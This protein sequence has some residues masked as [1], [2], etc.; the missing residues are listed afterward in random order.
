[1]PLPGM[2]HFEFI[3]IRK[4]AATSRKGGRKRDERGLGDLST[5]LNFMNVV[6]L[7]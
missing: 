5:G 1:M 3:F 2:I 4:L 7:R 6:T